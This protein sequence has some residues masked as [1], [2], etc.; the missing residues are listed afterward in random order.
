MSDITS[1]RTSE[2]LKAHAEM[3]TETAPAQDFEYWWARFLVHFERIGGSLD[4][5][6]SEKRAACAWFDI[7]RMSR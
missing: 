1:N 6:D 2:Y 4:N 5:L 7:G 3:E